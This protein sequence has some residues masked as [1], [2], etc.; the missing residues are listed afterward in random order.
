MWRKHPEFEETR[1][2]LISSLWPD[3]VPAN[4]DAIYENTWENVVVFFKGKDTKRG[5]KKKPIYKSI[6]LVSGS[7]FKIHVYMCYYSV[8]VSGNQYWMLR[9][10]KLEEGFPRSILT[11]GFPS[12]IKSV[13]AA[14]HFRDEGYTVFFTGDECWRYVRS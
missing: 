6:G 1:V 3:T 14:L 11:L 2:S 8:F 9:Q 10:L 5:K 7:R 12:R 4:L 13:D